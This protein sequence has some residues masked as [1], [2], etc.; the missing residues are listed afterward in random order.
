MQIGHI[1]KAS[2]HIAKALT[3]IPNNDYDVFISEHPQYKGHLIEPLCPVMWL[4]VPDSSHVDITRPPFGNI[5]IKNTDIDIE[6]VPRMSQ[7]E[8][9]L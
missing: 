3:Q 5:Y 1:S 9:S 6:Q 4:Y 7:A 2:P 8:I